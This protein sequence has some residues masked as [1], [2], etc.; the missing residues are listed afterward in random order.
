MS[1]S[2][3]LSIGPFSI[4]LFL[5]VSALIFFFSFLIG[6]ISL[7]GDKANRRIFSDL[8]FTAVLP[9]LLGWKF[10][11]VLTDSRDVFINPMLLLYGS[12]GILNVLIAALISG[13]WIAFRWRKK[14]SHKS[15][16]KAMRWALSTII[17]LTLAASGWIMLQS[18]NCTQREILPIVVFYD[19]NGEPWDI[20][21]AAGSPAVLNFWAS[22]CPPCRAEMPMLERIQ[23]DPRFKN[24][25]FYA[26]N[27]VRTEKNPQDGKKWLE[28]NN[29]NI[30]L[31][32]DN[33]G[34]GMLLYS[35]SGLPTTIVIDSEGRIVET[36][37]GA[38]SRSWLIG[39]IRKAGRKNQ[40][41]E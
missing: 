38:V 15:V 3:S 8:L 37:T 24:T 1:I 11:L 39:A 32:Y 34:Q 16:N 6:T 5:I 19:E 29:L 33:T 21:M 7:K 20:S 12:G 36:K 4:P 40:L 28:S 26:I 35:I 10:S 23:A 17:V 13:L 31:L 25:T 41:R 14:A 2:D 27:A 30:P 22:W 18:N 9:F